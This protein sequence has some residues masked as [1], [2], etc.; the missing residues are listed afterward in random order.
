[1]SVERTSPSPRLY[2]PE[3]LG[4]VVSDDYPPIPVTHLPTRY[5]EIVETGE[6]LEEVGVGFIPWYHSSG[7]PYSSEELLVR[8]GV[9]TR[10]LAAEESLPVG[11]G[12]VVL[13][14]W[15]DRRLQRALFQHHREAGTPAG[16]VADPEAPLYQPPHTTGGAVDVTLAWQ[17]RP[18]ALGTG[19]DAFDESAWSRALE[20]AGGSE[21]ARSLRR[22]L[23]AALVSQGFCPHPMEWWHF[24]FGDQIWAANRDG[25][26]AWYGPV[27]EPSP[28]LLE[29]PAKEDRPRLI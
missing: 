7:W 13:D 22:M 6:R 24:S 14:A 11:F 5:G 1:M 15:R 9:N 16:Y 3:E 29:Q 23:T 26:R 25:E 18:L 12:L 27:D 4:V 20:G 17:G 28:F 21:P 2:H 19:F 10:L 8:A